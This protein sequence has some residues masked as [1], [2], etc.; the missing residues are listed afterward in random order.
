MNNTTIPVEKN[1]VFFDFD[2]TLREEPKLLPLYKDAVEIFIG[3]LS[4]KFDVKNTDSIKRFVKEKTSFGTYADFDR[5]EK[6]LSKID[7]NDKQALAR[8]KHAKKKLDFYKTNEHFIRDSQFLRADYSFGE[9]QAFT[10]LL[11]LKSENHPLVFSLHQVYD[12]IFTNPALNH[13]KPYAAELVHALKQKGIMM[14]IVSNSDVPKIKHTFANE[15]GLMSNLDAVVGEKY[16]DS[17]GYE[18]NQ[19][20]STDMYHTALEKIE[21]KYGELSSNDKINIY[22]FGDRL[23]SDC[24]SAKFLEN[25]LKE[26]FPKLRVQTVLVADQWHVT[27]EEQQHYSTHQRKTLR[28]PEAK[29]DVVIHGFNDPK[30]LKLFH[31][32]KPLKRR[33]S[34]NMNDNIKSWSERTQQTSQLGAARQ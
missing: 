15:K 20:P 7:K 22:M 12:A 33:H 3:Y 18:N 19:K 11:G 4:N 26:K 31:L 6:Y 5:L 13:A 30:L 16:V 32:D 28:H 21:K 8:L 24:I 27:P 2:G 1:I 10:S 29:A 23:G 17:D 25:E 14:A 34:E 9:D